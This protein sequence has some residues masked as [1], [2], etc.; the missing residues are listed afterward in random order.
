[1]D[2]VAGILASIAERL[3]LDRDEVRNPLPPGEFLTLRFDCEVELTRLG[4]TWKS[5]R[6]RAFFARCNPSRPT[7]DGQDAAALRALLGK[8]RS[9]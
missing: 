1:M 3:E 4:L 5:E 9:L 8:L 7:L 2:D 6:V